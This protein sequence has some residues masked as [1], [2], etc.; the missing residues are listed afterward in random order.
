MSTIS[1]SS[2]RHS[3][4]ALSG[5]YPAATSVSNPAWTSAEAPPQ[6]TACSPKR[7]VS[8]SSLNVVSSTPARAAPMPAAYASAR[9]WAFP[10][11]SWCTAISAGVPM[12]CS[13]VR[14]TRWP[15]PFGAIIVTSTPSG[16]AIVPK[17]MLNP[18]ANISMLPASRFGPMSSA[19]AFDCAVSGRTTITTSASRTASAV[20]RT[21]RPA[22]SATLRD[23]D[24]GRRPTRT[25]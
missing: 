19:Y 15:G 11:A 17:W 22:S 21:R 9:P 3:K 12:P 4:Y 23:D 5:W 2:C 20:S 24:P 1:F 16:G 10:V 8:V 7:S 25:S 18:C 6:S 13:Y 14:R